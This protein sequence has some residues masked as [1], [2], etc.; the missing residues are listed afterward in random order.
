MCESVIRD[1]EKGAYSIEN[2]AACACSFVWSLSDD[3]TALVC[4]E[5]NHNCH[6]S[7]YLKVADKSILTISH[8]DPVVV[9]VD[10]V[11]IRD[12][13]PNIMRKMTKVKEDCNQLHHMRKRQAL[14]VWLIQAGY[15]IDDKNMRI[16]ECYI[17]LRDIGRKGFVAE[18]EAE[19]F[20]DAYL[21]GVPFVFR[22]CQ[23]G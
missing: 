10:R 20:A 16:G 19:I 13:P 2:K 9:E 3:Q 12:I 17:V 1:L 21:K 22:K 5:M 14:I 4:Q 15:Q 23:R 11:Q 18:N 6:H 7:S 8:G